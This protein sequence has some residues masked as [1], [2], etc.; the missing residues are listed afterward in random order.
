MALLPLINHRTRSGKPG[1][2]SP[3]THGCRRKKEEAEEVAP[4]SPEL[5]DKFGSMPDTLAELQAEMDQKVRC[6]CCAMLWCGVLCRTPW[7]SCRRRWTTGMLG[8]LRHAETPIANA[9]CAVSYLPARAPCTL[10]SPQTRTC[11]RTLRMCPSVHLFSPAPPPL[12]L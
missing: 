1:T 2:S 7:Q 4:L 8:L 11:S 6:A 9:C 10:S 3:P 5:N 12:P